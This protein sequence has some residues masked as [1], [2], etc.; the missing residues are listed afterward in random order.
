MVL[1]SLCFFFVYSFNKVCFFFMAVASVSSLVSS[2]VFSSFILPSIRP[3][4]ILP[5]HIHEPF[6]F[7]LREAKKDRRWPLFSSSTLIFFHPPLS[8]SLSILKLLSFYPRYFFYR[9]RAPSPPLLLTLSSSP[10]YVLHFYS[11]SFLFPTLLFPPLTLPSFSPYH[12]PFFSPPLL[13]SS[14]ILFFQSPVSDF[15]FLFL[16]LIILPPLT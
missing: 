16:L 11:F 6:L 8:L 9:L 2:F 1:Y 12:N 5:F 3:F 13:S 7:L 4:F 15:S 14:L 10:H